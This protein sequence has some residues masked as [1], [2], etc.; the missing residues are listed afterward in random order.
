MD[1]C[2][3]DE[4][5]ARAWV[6]RAHMTPLKRRFRPK[7]IWGAGCQLNVCCGLGGRVR[8]MSVGLWGRGVSE[9]DGTSRKGM[10]DPDGNQLLLEI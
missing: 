3:V 2:V 6:N 8:L 9:E 5:R 10:Y 4:P 7:N 1:T